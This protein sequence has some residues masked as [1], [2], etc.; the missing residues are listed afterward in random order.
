MRRILDLREEFA[1]R[2]KKIRPDASFEEYLCIQQGDK[3]IMGK[4]L[5]I[6]VKNKRF[7]VQ[8]RQEVERLFVQY[9]GDFKR[10]VLER[11]GHV[12]LGEQDKSLADPAKVYHYDLRLEYA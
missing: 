10:T 1:R 4:H 9:W 6:T 8:E 11:N 7:N 3:K 12:T 2:L 5:Q